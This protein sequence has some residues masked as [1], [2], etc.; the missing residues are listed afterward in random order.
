MRQF[1][2]Y[3]L[4]TSSVAILSGGLLVFGSDRFGARQRYLERLIAVLGY[5]LMV[6]GCLVF[7]A[8]LKPRLV[9]ELQR[10]S[11]RVLLRPSYPRFCGLLVRSCTGL[12]TTRA[13]ASFQKCST[14]W[15]RRSFWH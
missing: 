8:W 12:D 1:A 10:L 2:L 7:I 14:F 9:T 11:D 5:M 15:Q 6:G 13:Q 4:P 3:I